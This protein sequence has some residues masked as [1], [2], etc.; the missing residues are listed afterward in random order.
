MSTP[1]GIVQAQT[2]ALLRRVA[3]EQESRCRRARDA[4]Q[5]QAGSIVARAWE[6]A[7]ARLRQAVEEERRAVDKALADRR[8]ALE[9]AAR[10]REQAVLRELMDDAW[11]DLPGTLVSSWQRDDTRR[12]WCTAACAVAVRALHADQG[13][14]VEI[15]AALAEDARKVVAQALRHPS[16]PEVRFREVP[17]LGAGLRIHAGRACVDATVGGLLASRERI[18]SELLAEL[19]RLT[20]RRKDE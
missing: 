7:R 5:E 9:T 12:E 15:D 18:E 19:E 16:G 17:S 1:E 10:Q 4:A 20:E 8:A 3:R 13:Y 11:R 6:E 14:T 2:E